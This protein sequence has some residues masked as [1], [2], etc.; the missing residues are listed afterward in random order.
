[1][2]H[3]SCKNVRGTTLK[4]ISILFCISQRE[5][6]QL[7]CPEDWKF[8]WTMGCSELWSQG[9]ISLQKTCWKNHSSFCSWNSSWFQM[10]L[11]LGY[12]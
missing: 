12:N 8:S 1:M 4:H 9:K 11:G 2:N 10:S 5:W 3:K 6:S 7:C